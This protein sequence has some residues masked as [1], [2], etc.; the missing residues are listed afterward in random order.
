M[1]EPATERET[2]I[3]TGFHWAWWFGV[4]LVFSWQYLLWVGRTFRHFSETVRYSVLA[5]GLAVI[6]VFTLVAIFY[7]LRGR[8]RRRARDVSRTQA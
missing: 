6:F 3:E 8:R 7:D 1:A 2:Q 4:N 5:T